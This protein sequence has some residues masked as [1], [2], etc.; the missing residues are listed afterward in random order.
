MPLDRSLIRK[1]ML[2]KG[3]SYP[4]SLTKAQGP[5]TEAEFIRDHAYSIARIEKMI[6]DARERIEALR[7]KVKR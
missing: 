3:D 5:P 4:A 1:G 7:A 6:D 2:L